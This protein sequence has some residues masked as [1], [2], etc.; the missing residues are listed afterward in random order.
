MEAEELGWCVED[1]LENWEDEEEVRI[2]DA[3]HEASLPPPYEVNNSNLL[4]NQTNSPALQPMINH[5]NASPVLLPP[6]TLSNHINTP[7][8]PPHPLE[9]EHRAYDSDQEVE[10]IM[11]GTLEYLGEAKVE[12]GVR[13]E[14]P[15]PPPPEAAHLSPPVESP[16]TS[17]P[18]PQ[19]DVFTLAP[20]LEPKV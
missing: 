2:V 20:P 15:L 14:A 13:D 18:P 5:V 8:L 12:Q 19:A 6:P 4:A 1:P 11:R 7:P 16:C 10:I 17:P 3:S 9:H